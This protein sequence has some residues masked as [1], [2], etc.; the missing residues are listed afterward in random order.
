MGQLRDGILALQKNAINME[1]QIAAMEKQQD[2]YHQRV[3]EAGKRIG[4]G[5]NTLVLYLIQKLKKEGKTLDSEGALPLKS[6]MDSNVMS[7]GKGI[8]QAKTDV[9]GIIAK[10]NSEQKAAVGKLQASVDAS[11]ASMTK[12]KSIADKK[13][14]K[15]LKSAKYKAKIGGYLQALAAIDGILKKQAEALKAIEGINQND[16]W[17]EKNYKFSQDMTLKQVKGL[18][19][20]ELTS[21]LKD[22]EANVNGVQT[23]ARAFRDEYKNLK[24]QFALMK[25]WSEEADEMESEE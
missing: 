10:L 3:F 24:G 19:S 14:A 6:Q 7:F 16:A 13:K 12:L 8:A 2:D 15:W 23:R 18:Q 11:I 25:K 20:I 17:V 4:E 1:P 21:N 5:L 9:K 22:F